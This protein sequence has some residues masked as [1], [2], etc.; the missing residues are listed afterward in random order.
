VLP[1][2]LLRDLSEDR[3]VRRTDRAPVYVGASDLVTMRWGFERPGLGTVNNS[4]EDKL[5][6][7]M[8]RTAFRERR[9]LVPATRYYEFS[10]PKGERAAASKPVCLRKEGRE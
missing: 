8:W 9:C 5:D 10:G 6:G 3:L 7:P 1:D 2:G 4:R